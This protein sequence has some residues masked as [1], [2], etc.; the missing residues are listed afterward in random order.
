MLVVRP[1]RHLLRGVFFDRTGSKYA[2]RIW[3]FIKLLHTGAEG[4]GYADD[5]STPAW[6]VWHPQ[7]EPLLFDLLA[8]DIFDH[9]GR[10]TTFEE[11]ADYLKG[12]R[13][14]HNHIR[15]VALLLSGQLER[16]SEVLNE[17]ERSDLPPIWQSW[18]KSQRNL[19]N[20][21]MDAIYATFHAKEAETARNLKLGDVW[22]PTPFAGEV[23]EG[24][25]KTKCAEPFFTTSPWIGRPP[26]LVQEVPEH[27]GEIRFADD[28]VWRKGRV[29][30][31]V[32]LTRDAAEERHRTRQN[33]SLATR[34]P[35]GQLLVLHHYTSW[36]PH[37]PDPRRRSDYLPGRDFHLQVYGSMGRLYA[38][39]S[40][41]REQRG[42]L[43]MASA[44]VYPH[45]PPPDVHTH[46]KTWYPKW[47]SRNNFK[48]G[49]KAIYDRRIDPTGH[50]SPLLTASDLS[51]CRFAEPH[52]D[53]FGEF[54]QRIFT[55]LENEGFGSFT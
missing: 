34:L 50:T 54:W 52:F 5:I 44:D 24:A 14:G 13:D 45:H 19:L 6:Q 51:L 31:L 22:E 41:D 28:T 15:M 47:Y 12:H 53:E 1:V 20:R 35:A 46:P 25:L 27:P 48:A 17:M 36:S 3:S 49:W 2:F 39:F 30:M 16:A 4:I 9:V 40:E 21:D 11:F 37:D 55:Y 10:V 23:P 32:A 26:G 33:Y 38:H 42:V 7:F 8:E 43:Q 18:L 29:V